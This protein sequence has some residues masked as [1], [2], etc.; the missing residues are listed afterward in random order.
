MCPR[1]RSSG[2]AMKALL[3]PAAGPAACGATSPAA[4]Q[5]R[6]SRI[7]CR[8]S[9]DI[10]TAPA[11]HR[12]ASP[13]SWSRCDGTIRKHSR[14]A[15]PGTRAR[16][17]DPASPQGPAVWIGYRSF[18]PGL[19]TNG[20]VRATNRSVLEGDMSERRITQLF[21]LILG[22]LFTFGLVLNAFAF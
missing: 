16:G 18:Q 5:R 17:C 8:P 14:P 22:G 12:A 7:W 4:R 3:L 1:R 10:T 19:W 21:G 20:V 15:N 13:R 2:P 11:S 6:S 9:A